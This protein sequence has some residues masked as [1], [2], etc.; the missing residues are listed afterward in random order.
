MGSQGWS[1]RHKYDSLGP[2]ELV[3]AIKYVPA[4]DVRRGG[5]VAGSTQQA[6]SVTRSPRKL[7]TRFQVLPNP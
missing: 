3:V 6:R 1:R 2:R 7:R 4:S 5:P